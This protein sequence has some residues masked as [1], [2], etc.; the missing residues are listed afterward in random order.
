MSYT[1]TLFPLLEYPC[2]LRETWVICKTQLVPAQDY[3]LYAEIDELNF[4]CD[5]EVKVSVKTEPIPSHLWVQIYGDERLQRTRETN[6]G[7][8]LKFAYAQAF[9]KMRVP[10]NS[11]WQTKA[12]MAYI[13]ALPNDIPILV[14]F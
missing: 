14:C 13:K 5:G 4:L 9:K 8:V 6:Q 7:T 10:E 3:R 2:P 12:V 1:L 11:H